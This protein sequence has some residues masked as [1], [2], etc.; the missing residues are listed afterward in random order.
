[1]R[2]PF[3][4]V[5]LL[6]EVV[7]NLDDNTSIRGVLWQQRGPLLVLKNAVLLVPSGT[8]TPLDGEAIIERS[9]VVFIQAL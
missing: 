4:R 5:A 2:N 3:H 8:P 1:M 9:R 6:R 7:V